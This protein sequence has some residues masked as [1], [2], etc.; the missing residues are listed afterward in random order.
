M[1]M[2]SKSTFS[3]IW[4]VNNIPIGTERLHAEICNLHISHFL[5]HR[6]FS[7]FHIIADETIEDAMVKRIDPFNQCQ[8]L[9]QSNNWITDCRNQLHYLEYKQANQKN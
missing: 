3:R 5:S 9:I 7:R 2:S 1:K 6:S 4:Q 8:V